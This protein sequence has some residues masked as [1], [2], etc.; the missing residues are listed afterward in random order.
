EMLGVLVGVIGVFSADHLLMQL[1]TWANAY[2]LLPSLRR[3]NA[4]KVGDLHGRDFLHV[5]LATFHILEGMPYQLYALFQGDH[6]A[7]HAFVGNWQYAL[8][9]NRHKERN[10]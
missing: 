10:N 7:R 6:E 1:F 2:D 5:D 4:G 9:L 8:V 3:D